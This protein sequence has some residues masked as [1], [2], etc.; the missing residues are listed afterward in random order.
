MSAEIIK[1]PAPWQ[2]PPRNGFVEMSQIRPGI[3]LV[4]G[5]NLSRGV[6]ECREFHDRFEAV[7]FAW[8]WAEREHLDMHVQGEGAGK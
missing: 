8:E 6:G 1:L 5:M 4:Q 7:T 2:A 3:W